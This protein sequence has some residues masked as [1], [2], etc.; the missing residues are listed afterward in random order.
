MPFPHL[1]V[2]SPIGLLGGSD[3]Q[4]KGSTSHAARPVHINNLGPRQVEAGSCIK[5]QTHDDS[6]LDISSFYP[7]VLL[8][9]PSLSHVTAVRESRLNTSEP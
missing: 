5:L 6:P 2:K 8:L 9:G 4:R 3:V 7:K 1:K